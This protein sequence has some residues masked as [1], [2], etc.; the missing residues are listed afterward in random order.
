MPKKLNKESL[1]EALGLLAEKLGFERAEAVSLVVC[2]G[3]ALIATGLV[4]RTTKDVDVLALV[5]SEG[6]LLTSEPL[7]EAVVRAAAEIAT[8]LGLDPKWLNGGPTELLRWGLPEGFRS[9]LTLRE[10]GPC[11]TVSFIGRLDQIYFKVFA[12]TDAG[13]GR[14]VNDLLALHPTEV[15]LVVGAKWAL[16][17]DGSEEFAMT[18]RDMMKQLGYENVAKLI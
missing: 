18:L 15:E 2:G 8:Q 9:R 13:P 16:T 6:E 4:S 7:P 5:N 11:L 12:A 3:S 1:D 17:Q 14:H 10:Y